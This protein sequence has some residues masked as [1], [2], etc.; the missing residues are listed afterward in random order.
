MK[1]VGDIVRETSDKQL[2]KDL[3]SNSNLFLFKY[4]GVS[5]AD[6]NQ[7]RRGLKNVKAKM[8]ITK[9]NFINLSLKTENRNKEILDFIDGPT[10]LVF[11]KDDPI[12][13]S[14]V[15]TD[16]AKTHETIV[17]KG[18]YINDR[19][20]HTQDFK[21]L[22]N[23]PSKQAIYQQ[24]AV[25]FNGP[26]TNLAINLKQ[27]TAKLAYALKSLSEKREKEKK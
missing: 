18:G 21:I 8:F 16:F 23:I 15:L 25:V 24:I 11:V 22:A 4:S 20:I 2:K 10:A 1:K 6:L 19:V 9:N 26:I 7:L 17:L 13:P 3:S 12:A 5:A 27:I 14:K